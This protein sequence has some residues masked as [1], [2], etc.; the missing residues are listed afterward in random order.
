MDLLADGLAQIVGLRGGEAGDLL[1]DLHRLLLVDRDPVGRAGDLLQARVDVRDLL[2]PVLP[3]R[4]DRDVLHRPRA[5]ERDE[6]DQVLEHGGLH[7]A[8]RLAHARRL[9][10]EDTV[11]LAAREHRVGLLVVERD[12]PDVEAAAD[13]RDRL[14]DHVEVAQA[15]EVHLQQAERLDRVHR[16][17]RHDFLVGALLLERHDLHQRRRADHDAGG[18]DRV[19]PRQPFE[20]PREVDDLARDGIGVVRHLQVGARLEAVLERSGPGLPG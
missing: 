16:E 5:V 18:V 17:L 15:E 2:L 14:V 7:L 13:Q 11:R 4:V 9:E 19:L 20:R 8:E 1:C 12:R 6:R 3:L 10:L